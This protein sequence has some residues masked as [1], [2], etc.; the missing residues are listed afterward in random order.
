M[1][2]IVQA[3]E[4]TDLVPLEGDTSKLNRRAAEFETTYH[5]AVKRNLPT[6]LPLTMEILSELH[7]KIKNSAMSDAS[8][9]MVIDLFFSRTR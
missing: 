2:C 5:D 3:I 4:S 9:K 8:K 1:I 7:K 6:Y